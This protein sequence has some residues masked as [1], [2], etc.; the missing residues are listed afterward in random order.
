MIDPISYQW[1][2][3]SHFI[4]TFQDAAIP[5]NGPK[6]EAISKKSPSEEPQV[7]PVRVSTEPHNIETTTKWDETMH[8]LREGLHC[9]DRPR[10]SVRQQRGDYWVL[11][12]YVQS[13]INYK[14][15]E[16][17]T[18]TTHGD[19]S[20]LDNLV[21]LLEHWNGPISIALHA[22]GS[23]F[24]P[25]I[26]SI[27][28]LRECTSPLVKQFVTFHAY[29]SAKHIPSEVSGVFEKKSWLFIKMYL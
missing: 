6:T 29:F 22:P 24:K 10:R 20:F 21:P 5:R 19:Y 3:L 16:S 12:N 8:L 1:G 11:Y 4:F 17:V 2:W 9:V 7:L 28:Y 26:E 18:Y 13:D 14:C 25:T 27:R 23:D 15:H